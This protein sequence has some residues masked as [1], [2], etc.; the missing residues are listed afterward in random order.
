MNENM[1]KYG[2]AIHWECFITMIT[3]KN[4][5][6]LE[7]NVSLMD[8]CVI[9]RLWLEFCCYFQWDFMHVGAH[10]LNDGIFSEWSMVCLQ[11][12]PKQAKWIIFSIKVQFV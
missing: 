3:L 8:S 11:M 1:F 6:W 9:W 2:L 4:H 5:S 12:M 10:S 7:W